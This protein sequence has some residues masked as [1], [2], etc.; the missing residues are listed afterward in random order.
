MILFFCAKSKS[1]K[2]EN[3]KP[4][5]PNYSIEKEI[6]HQYIMY[7]PKNNLNLCRKTELVTVGAYAMVY[8]MSGFVCKIPV[9]STVCVKKPNLISQLARSYFKH[10]QSLMYYQGT[11]GLNS[12]RVLHW[13]L[14]WHWPELNVCRVLHCD[15]AKFVQ[16]PPLSKA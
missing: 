10:C 16:I 5:K 13:H 11:M 7:C 9:Y 1:K 15:G 6:A 12:F 2:I 3:S 4:V 8:F 14:L